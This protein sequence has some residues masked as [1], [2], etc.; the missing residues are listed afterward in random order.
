MGGAAPH[1]GYANPM[2]APVAMSAP[3][4][5]QGGYGGNMAAPMDQMRYA[6]AAGYA[7]PHQIQ[8]MNMGGSAPGGTGGPAGAMPPQ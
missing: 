5:V 7:M 4:Q 2:S 6:N 3:M 8:R 1:M